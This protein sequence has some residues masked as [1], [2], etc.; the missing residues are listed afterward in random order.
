VTPLGQRQLTGPI[1]G[2][3]DDLPIK[4]LEI[5]YSDKLN[6]IYLLCDRK[7]KIIRLIN[8]YRCLIADTK[9]GRVVR[10]EPDYFTYDIDNPLFGSRMPYHS[11]EPVCRGVVTELGEDYLLHSVQYFKNSGTVDPIIAREVCNSIDI[12]HRRLANLLG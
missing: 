1:L 12:L 9:P 10:T 7:K 11:S 4:Q 3:N 5:E 6:T 8:G 2:T